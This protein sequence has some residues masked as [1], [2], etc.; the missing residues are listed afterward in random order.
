MFHNHARES[1]KGNS[2]CHFTLG[3]IF[4]AMKNQDAF[5]RSFDENKFSDDKT[6][7]LNRESDDSAKG[8]EK[9]DDKISVFNDFSGEIVEG[10]LNKRSINL[11][12]DVVDILNKNS[13]KRIAIYRDLLG[14]L[15]KSAKSEDLL[16]YLHKM[17]A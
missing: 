3:A 13:E 5:H 2:D 12:D 1:G 4:A 7:I 6:L 15:S 11:S 16:F 17:H 10:P 9:R 14:T 8:R